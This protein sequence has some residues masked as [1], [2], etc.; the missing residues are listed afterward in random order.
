MKTLG[1]GK[2]NGN[3]SNPSVPVPEENIRCPFAWARFR[4]A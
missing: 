1:N 4:T 2:G 3:G